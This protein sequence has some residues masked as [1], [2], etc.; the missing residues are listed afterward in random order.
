MSTIDTSIVRKLYPDCFEGGLTYGPGDYDPLVNSIG[1]VRI[2]IDDS[3]YQ[4]D[5][6]VLLYNPERAAFG[7]L[8]FGWGSCSGCDSLQACQSFEEVEELRQQ[9]FNSVKWGDPEELIHYIKTHD[10]EG[11]Y[12]YHDAKPELFE[13]LEAA[14]NHLNKTIGRKDMTF[15]ITEDRYNKIAENAINRLPLGANKHELAAM[16]YH[17][18]TAV[19]AASA[20]VKKEF[21]DIAQL[22]VI[23]AEDRIFI[24]KVL[25][26]GQIMAE[27]GEKP[28]DEDRENVNK[29]VGL[30]KPAKQV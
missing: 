2:K 22:G 27:N 3:D 11:D 26:T 14:E 18:A 4:G 7:I 12:S 15:T 21:K 9:M 19:I 30:L 16:V 29:A 10:W 6:R 28:T 5:S 24:A 13:F 23:S 1:D 17:L 25:I 8:I 20:G